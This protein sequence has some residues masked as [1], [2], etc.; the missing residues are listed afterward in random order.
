MG[1]MSAK[2]NKTPSICILALPE[3]S[4]A[5]LYGLFE[6]FTVFSEQWAKITGKED[7]LAE[8][9]V[10]IVAPSITPFTC[11]GGVP[12]TP[13]AS[14]EEINHID[15]VIIT[16]LAVDP[17]LDH[18]KRWLD[19]ISWLHRVHDAGG[20]LCS[21]CSG[22]VLLAAS[23]LLDGRQATT[24]WAFIDHFRQFFPAVKLEPNRILIPDTEDIHIVTMGGMSAWEDLALYLMAR[25]YGEATAIRAAKLFL[26]GDR[27]EGQLLFSAMVKPKRHEDEVIAKSQ[28]W[29]SSHYDS[30][31]PVKLMVKQS[32][33]A[34]RTFKRRFKAA[35]GYTPID[36]IQTLR[37]EEAKQM[38]ETTADAID[39]IAK[40]A[41]YEDPT[42]FR[43]L[44]KR[45]TGV[46][47]G[48]YRQR[49]R[50]INN[51]GCTST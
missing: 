45:L 29:I 7:H 21:V 35:T 34:E 18:S 20:L 1:A 3:S 17:G 22:S 9:D 25:F 23:G 44:F 5:V 31:N 33:L 32:G 27:S 37:V 10:K 2:Y 16:D 4:G 50:S 19:I 42:S 49:F 13:H 47:P 26:I 46:T 14:Y 12:V 39:I 15:V 38:L 41:G 40:Q 36:Y 8:F 6:V 30:P 48:R 11:V 43:R 24:H 28:Q 51:H